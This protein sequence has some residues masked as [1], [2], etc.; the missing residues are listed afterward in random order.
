MT[1]LCVAFLI[2]GALTA[3]SSTE[4]Q[5]PTCD[6]PEPMPEIAE[7]LSV[8]QMP[9]EVR[10]DAETATF[11]LEG[12]LQLE[13]VRQA[14]LAN[15]DIGDRNT[16]A[17]AARNEEVNALIECARYQKVWMEGREDM[18]EQERKAHFIDNTWHR[19]VI[20]LGLI[21]VAL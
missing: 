12:V 13:R 21:A 2:A 19:G 16:A 6:I 7:L 3:C 1:R 18:L 4:L 8:P 17:L 15:K 10:S 11:D 5:L 9:Q 14:A 20:A